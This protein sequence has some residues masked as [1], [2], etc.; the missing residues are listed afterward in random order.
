MD[1]ASPMARLVLAV[2]LAASGVAKL[3][4][5]AGA[6]S[7]VTE[8]GVPAALASPLALILPLAELV[9]ATTLVWDRSATAGAVAAMVILALFTAAITLGVAL[10]RRP[11]C[12]CFGRLTSKPAGGPAIARNVVLGG[13]AA[14]V[15]IAGPGASVDRAVAWVGELTASSSPP[16][17]RAR[18]PRGARAP[19]VVHR[20]PPSPERTPRPATWTRSR[21]SCRPLPAPRRSHGALRP[22]GRH[23]AGSGESTLPPPER[24]DI[25]AARSCCTCF[26]RSEPC[27]GCPKTCFSFGFR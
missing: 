9:I 2:V 11:E 3:A 23:H 7:A 22:G 18:A 5:R 4:D 25:S 19:V 26:G 14:C 24:D 12:H 20:E 16:W 27:R 8:L 1:V 10:G 13:L 15:A 6:R 17:R 21:P